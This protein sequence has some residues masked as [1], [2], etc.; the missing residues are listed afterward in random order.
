MEA[1]YY[2][3]CTINIGDRQKNRAKINS[4]INC[5]YKCSEII[6]CIKKYAPHKKINK[7]FFF[8]Y[9]N[10]QKKILKILKSKKIWKLSNQKQFKDLINI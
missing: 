5:S 10:S 1:P 3:T 8:G 4:I 9:G 2:G 6:K 7:T